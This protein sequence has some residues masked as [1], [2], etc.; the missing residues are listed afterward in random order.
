MKNN[1]SPKENLD[2]SKGRLSNPILRF[3]S[4]LVTLAAIFVLIYSIANSFTI[5]SIMAGVFFLI[6]WFFPQ[7]W[8]WIEF[9]FSKR[10]SSTLGRLVMNLVIAI[11]MASIIED[12]WELIIKL[13]R[14]ILRFIS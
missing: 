5:F 2:E 13:A 11:L 9:V 14:I 6:L 8:D 12:A 4:I 3:A 7:V 10:P 1:N